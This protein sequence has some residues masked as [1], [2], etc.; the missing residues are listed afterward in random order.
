MYEKAQNQSLKPWDALRDE[1]ASSP[2][3]LQQLMSN[4]RSKFPFVK[5]AGVC[6]INF[7][8]PVP[9]ARSGTIHVLGLNPFSSPCFTG[10]VYWED[11]RTRVLEICTTGV[12]NKSIAVAPI[13]GVAGLK[14]MPCQKEHV[15]GY[16]ADGAYVNRVYLWAVCFVAYALA[17]QEDVPSTAMVPT[18]QHDLA[19]LKATH[20]R[21]ASAEQRSLYILRETAMASKENR[22]LDPFMLVGL[23]QK[24][25]SMSPDSIRSV[26]TKHNKSVMFNTRLQIQGKA[27]FRVRSLGSETSTTSSNYE[28]MEDKVNQKGWS[29]G[30]WCDSFYDI[31]AFFIGGVARE[32][33]HPVWISVFSATEQSQRAAIEYAHAYFDREGRR[34]DV[35]VFEA[36]V[37]RLVVMVSLGELVLKPAGVGQPAI[38]GAVRGVSEG[39]YAYALDGFLSMTLDE[40]LQ[41]EKIREVASAKLPFLE[42][43]INSSKVAGL[44]L[45]PAKVHELEAAEASERTKAWQNSASLDINNYTQAWAAFQSTSDSY[46]G[47]QESHAKRRDDNAESRP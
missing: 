12:F 25:Y 40:G 46:R 34:P 44:G 4:V 42:V 8:K 28:V 39:S 1:Y 26:I 19:A 33:S 37:H 20:T 38:D 32:T 10:N 7:Q 31:P 45:T 17:E 13:H 16:G 22:H 9:T 11:L 35:K 18:L 30:P 2:A 41:L 47:D 23:L 14:V 27:D 5:A 3:A 36:M 29:E 15:L 43:L 6:Y 24:T 21:H